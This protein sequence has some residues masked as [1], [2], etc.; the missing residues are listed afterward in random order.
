MSRDLSESG[1][2]DELR[3]APVIVAVGIRI[4]EV[5]ELRSFFADLTQGTEVAFVLVADGD[6]AHPESLATLVSPHVDLPVVEAAE[7]TLIEAG[8]LYTPPTG[9]VVVVKGRRFRLQPSPA[10]DDHVGPID[11]LLF[12]LAKDQQSRAAAVLLSPGGGDGTRGLQAIREAGGRSF[13]RKRTTDGESGSDRERASN[14]VADH[15]FP[16]DRLMTGLMVH[17]DHVLV[18]ERNGLQ[19]PSS[20][21]YAAEHLPTSVLSHG[22]DM[23]RDAAHFRA[24]IDSAPVLIWANDRHGNVFLNRACRDFFGASE[25]DFR[26]NGWSNFIHEEDREAFTAAYRVAVDRQ[27]VFEGQCRVLRHD[28]MY[29]WMQSIALPRFS[30]E[31][32]LVGYVGSSFDISRMKSSE[33]TLRESEQWFKSIADNAP[34]MLWI[35]DEHHRCTYLSRGWLEFTGQTEAEGLGLGWADAVHPD[36]RERAIRHFLAAAER[37]Q[38]FSF[39]YRLRTVDGGFRWAIDAARP[40]FDDAGKFVGYIG[41][42]ID[43]DERKGAEMQLARS[44]Q[45]YRSLFDNNIDGIVSVDLNGY[46]TAANPAALEMSGYSMDELRYLSFIHLCAPESVDTL[47]QAFQR[48]LRGEALSIELTMIRK[49]GKTRD[50]IV[51]GAPIY[52]D[53]ELRELFGITVD[54]TER[55]EAVAKLRESEERFREMANGLPLIVWVHD[56]TGKQE[57]VNDT[58]CEY[59]GITREMLRKERWR[60]L[61]H[62]EDGAAYSEQFMAA[63]REQRSFHAEAR[64]RRADGEWRWMESWGRPRLSP[65]GEFLGHIGTSVDVTERKLY[66]L[67]LEEHDRRTNSFLTKLARELRNPLAPIRTGLELLQQVQDD[68]AIREEVR[69]T[70]QRQTRQLIKLVDNLVD[71]SQ[72]SRGQLELHKRPMRL[73]EVAHMAVEMTRPM[74]DEGG[75]H[76]T[77]D[78]EPE[79]EMEADRERLAQV[80]ANLLNNAAKYTPHG[81]Q[82]ILKTARHGDEVVLIVRDSGIGIPL[83]MRERVFDA[84]AHG[85]PTAADGDAWPHGH[86]GLGIGL[87]LVKHLAELHGGRVEVFSEGAN[88]GSQ[89]TVRLPA[90]IQR[91]GDAGGELRGESSDAQRGFV[92]AGLVDGIRETASSTVDAPRHVLVVDDNFAAAKLLEMSISL[93]GHQVRLAKDGI[94]AV[95]MAADFLPDV[96]FMDIGMPNMDGY[97]AARHIRQQPWGQAMKLVAL[98]GW[99]QDEDIRQSR[100]AG[101]NEHLI[102]PAES[103]TL[104]RLITGIG[105]VD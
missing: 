60:L 98:T 61:V 58:F 65:N 86:R 36:D 75:H 23:D 70:I 63:V 45:R 82:L 95:R 54:V 27:E 43:V 92:G 42:V 52:V 16:L 85:D 96:V 15:V 91:A 64:V 24:V 12:S 35:T 81:G 3:T 99:G 9:R 55:N 53:G 83:E 94:E 67:S 51:H 13:L 59:F 89:F 73:E 39:D 93:L 62:D 20:A 4:G 11:R 47:I 31:G 46:F 38:P 49:D 57:F 80:L 88:R 29:R 90:P 78:L 104:R 56:A 17:I 14:G 84:F 48:G 44:E 1:S 25:A 71:I 50:L 30:D 5:A 68:A 18:A 100:E 22:L 2:L 87:T 74:I 72:V 28:G 32:W 69:G 40:R 37:Q 8:R 33:R 7:G 66:E 21:A 105:S 41:S 10:S 19:W 77:L 103:E 6:T 101:F 34:A 102:K 26:H 79:I 76:L 97:E